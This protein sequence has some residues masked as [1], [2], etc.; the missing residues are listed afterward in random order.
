[1]TPTYKIH[2]AIGLA[3][4]GN[5]PDSFYLAPERTGA[6]PIDCGVD[7]LPIVKDGAEL[8]VTKYKDSKN[9][10][11]RQAARFRV[12]GYDDT[13]P[14]GRELKLGDTVSNVL[15]RIGPAVHRHAS[16]HHVDRLS[17]Q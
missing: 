13:T 15:S 11:R 4:V 7:G 16:R 10:I 5:S 3:R 14:N 9:R 17:R 2:P 6:A 12:Y 8:P 1:M